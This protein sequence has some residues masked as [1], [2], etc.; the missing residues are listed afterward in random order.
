M[1][2]D[3]N[4]IK[5]LL[6]NVT[7]IQNYDERS[8]YVYKSSVIKYIATETENDL[9]L[10]EKVVK[11]KVSRFYVF[12]KQKETESLVLS[13]GLP[14]EQS[15]ITKRG[16]FRKKFKHAV[17]YTEIP[18]NVPYRKEGLARTGEVYRQQISLDMPKND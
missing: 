13:V 1:D 10:S 15:N 18:S 11:H 2:I 6:F 4:N 12:D 5:K 3:G 7:K 16:C 14:D 8:I 17:T 9:F